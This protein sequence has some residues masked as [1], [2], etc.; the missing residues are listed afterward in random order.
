MDNA[1]RNRCLHV[2]VSNMN[3]VNGKF[4]NGAMNAQNNIIA[5]CSATAAIYIVDPVSRM[6]AESIVIPYFLKLFMLILSNRKK[7]AIS[8][9]ERIESIGRSS[10]G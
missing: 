9:E 8:R 2:F 7:L 3:P 10:I 6:R 4:K 1:R 5:W